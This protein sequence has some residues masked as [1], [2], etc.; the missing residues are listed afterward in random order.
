MRGPPS[1]R[2]RGFGAV[3][4]HLNRNLPKWSHTRKRVGVHDNSPSPFFW[5]IRADARVVK[6]MAKKSSTP[7]SDPASLAFSAVED[8]LK[9]SVFAGLD[10]PDGTAE[11]Q[12]P[13]RPAPREGGNGRTE[14]QR[15]ADKYA[16]QTG[17]VANDD[18]FQHSKILYGLQNRPSQRPTL[19]A[20]GVAAVW[21]VGLVL[22]ALARNG[23]AIASGTFFG[24]DEFIGLVALAVI[25]VLGFFAIS[26]LVRR[27]Q[28]L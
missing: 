11:K 15:T 19:I 3:A 7:Q 4:G 27:A 6:S 9:D 8:A 22:V 16:A 14:R 5:R 13:V 23:D 26:T 25:P 28:D 20:A 2:R 17:S 24:S 10:Q 1:V 21:V 18:R 12:G